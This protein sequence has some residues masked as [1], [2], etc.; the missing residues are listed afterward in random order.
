M[1]FHRFIRAIVE[2]S[3][4]DIYG[5]GNQTRDFT[6]VDDTVQ[7]TI[8]AAMGDV[9]GEVLNIGGGSRVTVNEVIKILESLLNNRANVKY[10][11]EQKGD[12]R[13]T[14]ADISKATLSLGYQ[15]KVS[16]REGLSREATW[17]QNVTVTS[18]AS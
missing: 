16:L 8:K 4:I 14:G 7:G 5:D 11:A 15:P 18:V 13:H 10:I 17:L 12:V 1:A 9:S 2:R 6:Y 3:E